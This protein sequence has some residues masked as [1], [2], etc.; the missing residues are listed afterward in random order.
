MAAF[1]NKCPQGHQ[2]EK[3][4]LSCGRCYAKEAWKVDVW[5][6]PKGHANPSTQ[7][8]CSRCLSFAKQPEPMAKEKLQSDK[9]IQRKT[10]E[11][12][13]RQIGML[14]SA[15]PAFDHYNRDIDPLK[16][17]MLTQAFKDHLIESWAFY[18]PFYLH[19]SKATQRCIWPTPALKTKVE[20]I[21]RFVS[22]ALNGLIDKPQSIDTL[23]TVVESIENIGKVIYLEG[24]QQKCTIRHPDLPSAIV[25]DAHCF[26]ISSLPSV[27]LI[28]MTEQTILVDYFFLYI[29]LS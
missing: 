2:I 25:L 8:S 27:K 18:D 22:A 9:E 14:L 6:C 20:N 26:F 15:A 23:V 17:G 10:A 11:T 16:Q 4:A 7:L 13:F 3:G 5:K 28:L 1:N 29:L 24:S 19:G 12:H 21:N